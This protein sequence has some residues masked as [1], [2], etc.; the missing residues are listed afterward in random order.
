MEEDELDRG[1][2]RPGPVDDDDVGGNRVI[3]IDLG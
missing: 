2:G 1:L 3:V